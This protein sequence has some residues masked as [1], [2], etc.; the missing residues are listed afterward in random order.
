MHRYCLPL[1]LLFAFFAAP[2][3]GAQVVNTEKL[4][5][6]DSQSTWVGDADLSFGLTRNKAGQTL[7][8]GA[9][10]RV[11]HLRG[12]SRW[13]AL[14][15]YGLTQFLN[16]DD[17]EAVPKNFRNNYFGHLRYN[18]RFSDRLTLEAFSQGQYDEI[19]EIDVRLLNGLGPRLRLA[20]TDSTHLYFGLLY[21]YEYEET[22]EFEDRIVFNKDHRLSSYLS[23]GFRIND[24]LVVDHVTYFQPN[25]RDFGDFRISSETS[26]SVAITN[27]LSFDTYFQLIYDAQPPETVPETMY[28]L[29]NGLNLSF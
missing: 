3:A 10:G 20:R 12:R 2:E 17:S 4:R 28:M 23:G 8:L 11:E 14:A 5:L 7:A 24:N 25:L 22:S 29:R 19:Q 13:M 21:M 26:I 6:Q 1:F 16:V 9:N 15:G 27:K 18:Y